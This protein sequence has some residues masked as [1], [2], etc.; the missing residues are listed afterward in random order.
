MGYVY[1]LED[2]R[3]GKKYIGKHNGKKEDYWSSGLVPNK[4]ASKYGR[5]VFERV[6]LEDN[7]DDSLLN[8]K[9]QYYINKYNTFKDG[10]NATKGGE[11]GNHWVYD[12][13]EEELEIIKMKKS[14][15]L[16]GRVFSDESRMKMSE[17][18]RGKKLSEEHKKNIGNAVRKRGGIPHTEETKK[19]ISEAHK[20][21]KNENHSIYMKKN[22]PNAQKVSINGVVYDMIK[23]ASD[24]LNMSVSSIKY[25]LNSDKEEYKKWFKIKKIN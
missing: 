21:K 12:K 5:D 10:Y 16:K 24:R 23:M 14:K 15:K 22:N 19:K 9:E 1:M 17:S 7:I 4:V 3:N 20:G 8:Q 2:K 6:I 18:H 25:R 13:S 11:G